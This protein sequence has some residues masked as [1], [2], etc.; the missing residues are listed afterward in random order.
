M[1]QDTYRGEQMEPGTWNLYT[2]CAND[3]VNYTDPSGHAKIKW[4][5]KV[6]EE[7]KG[8][9]WSQIGKKYLSKKKSKKTK[10]RKYFRIGCKAKYYIKYW[11]LSKK[12]KYNCNVYRNAI[13]VCNNYLNEMQWLLYD[14]G[15]YTTGSLILALCRW[16]DAAIEIAGLAYQKRKKLADY[17]EIWNLQYGVV[18]KYYETIKKYGKKY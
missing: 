16:G 3:P 18:K 15:I 6:Y 5:K 8:K 12:K 17:A 11:K 2:Y 4:G 13:S 7:L 1:S 14:T 10:I 9:Y